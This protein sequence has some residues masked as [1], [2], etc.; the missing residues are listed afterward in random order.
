MLFRSGAGY[1]SRSYTS[2]YSDPVSGEPR[3]GRN[4]FTDAFVP[5]PDGGPWVL[6]ERQVSS[7]DDAARVF[8]FLD[9]EALPPQA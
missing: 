7:E 4:H 9:L 1:L 5:L 8:R 2:Q 3:G 6:G